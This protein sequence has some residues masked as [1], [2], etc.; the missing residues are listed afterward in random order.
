MAFDLAFDRD[1]LDKALVVDKVFG[2]GIVDTQDNSDM[3]DMLGKVLVL[4]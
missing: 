3:W 1:I 4:L 2:L